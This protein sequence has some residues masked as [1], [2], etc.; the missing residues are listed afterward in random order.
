[1]SK[2]HPLEDT[3]GVPVVPERAYLVRPCQWEVVEQLRERGRVVTYQ[4]DTEEEA[5]EQA[6]IWRETWRRL[7]F[8]EDV[9]QETK[10]AQD[11]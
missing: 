8:S 6:S 10:G 11:Q 1:M 9:P 7:R 4:F 2:K 5:Q 3:E